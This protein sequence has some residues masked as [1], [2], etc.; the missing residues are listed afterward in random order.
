MRRPRR[1]RRTA[2]QCPGD[3]VGHLTPDAYRVGMLIAL[4][5][6]PSGDPLTE[7]QRAEVELFMARV[8]DRADTDDDRAT[9]RSIF[10]A[11][12]TGHHAGSLACPRHRRRGGA[13]RLRRRTAEDGIPADR[14]R[15]PGAVPRGRFEPTSR[16][17]SGAITSL[18]PGKTPDSLGES[19]LRKLTERPVIRPWSP[20]ENVFPCLPSGP[21]PLSN[22][23]GSTA[24]LLW[25]GSS[26]PS[27]FLAGSSGMFATA[28]KMITAV[29]RPG[30]HRPRARTPAKRR[31][32]VNRLGR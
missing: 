3:E 17:G 32:S 29:V 14:G 6:S 2:T 19:G 28:M 15:A 18:F 4:S 20:T 12:A 11:I 30:N 10:E 1:R 24:G 8:L 25:G 27:C 21:P 5:K 23:R 9:L 13:R 7:A 16:R 31:T 22:R 26:A